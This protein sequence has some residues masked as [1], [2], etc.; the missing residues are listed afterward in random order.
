V[1][2]SYLPVHFSNF[3]A[4]LYDLDTDKAIATGNYGNLVVARKQNVPVVVPI[5]FSYSAVNATDTTC[6][7][8]PFGSTL[9]MELMI[10][11]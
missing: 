5:E 8:A 11:V 10:R 2:K 7:S 3:E 9:L 6:Q 4:T 1:T